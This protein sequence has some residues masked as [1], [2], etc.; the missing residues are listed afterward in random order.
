M[1]EQANFWKGEFGDDYIGRN[2]FPSLMASN[3]FLFGQI[4]S[5]CPK[6][7]ASFLELGPNIGM[8][9]RALSLLSPDCN[10]LGS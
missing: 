6:M 8:N 5:K 2:N 7:P 4:L 10:F 9:F 1:T 3:L